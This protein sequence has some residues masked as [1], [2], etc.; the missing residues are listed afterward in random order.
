MTAPQN[1]AIK[2]KAELPTITRDNTSIDAIITQ[3][4]QA[5]ASVETM[6]KIFSL[7][8]KMKAEQAKEAFVSALANF[9][10][11]C[12]I[13]EK[14]KK[15]FNK[16]GKTVRYIF[17]PIDSIV[18]QIRESLVRNGLS[19]SWTIE[20]QPT[21]VKAICTI[22]HILGHKE[23]SSFEVP[24]DPESYMTAP[25]RYA[26]ASTFARRYSLCNALGISTGDEDL[27]G[28]NVNKEKDAKS[29]KSK[30]V[31]QLRTLGNDTKTKT[32]IEKA[33]L[34]HTQLELKEEN[35]V[36]ISSRLGIL[37]DESHESSEIR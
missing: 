9:Q 10:S 35:Y 16:D 36:E 22:T 2:V 5:N 11:S 21:M 17:A 24:I 4:I 20:N 8:E 12:P 18:E 23:T 27:D 34:E 13:I 19:Y 33:V 37:I 30:I 15:V 7:R 29:I 1:K 6:E 28:N 25:Q 26:S 3:A 31:L 14:K 32:S